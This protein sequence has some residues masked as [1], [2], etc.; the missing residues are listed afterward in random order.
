[1]PRAHVIANGRKVTVLRGEAGLTQADL[2][3]QAGFGL[4]T[5]GKLE[6]GQPTSALTLSAVA[7]VLSRKLNRMLSLGDLLLRPA[8]TG[9]VDSPG[10]RRGL[11][12]SENEFLIAEQIKVLDLRRWRSDRENPVELI[13]HHR[14]QR[15]PV[16][17]REISF[18]YG[19]TGTALRGKCLSH[20]DRYEW[21]P[22]T[23][24]GRYPRLNLACVLRLR[25]AGAS[26]PAG[27]DIQNTIE[28]LDGF[29]GADREWFQAPITYPTESLTLLLLFPDRK[30]FQTMRGLSQRRSSEPFR[31]L[32]QHPIEMQGG[33]LACWRISEPRVGEMYRIEWEW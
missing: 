21:A 29:G 10:L 6:N 13:D 22:V 16:G 9:Q 12:G 3:A 28:Y 4:R 33:R 11:T 15:L 19:T 31:T 8:E 30:P 1:M 24:N 32:H 23:P 2:A 26:G 17:V 7:T 25:L 14:F 20:P 5:I 18:H 27:C